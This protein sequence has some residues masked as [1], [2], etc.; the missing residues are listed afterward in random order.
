MYGLVMLTALSSGADPT[1]VPQAVP[2][3]MNCTGCCGAVVSG[4][5]GCYGSYYV[6]RHKHGLFGHHHASCMGCTGYSCDGW[7]CFGS[8]SGCTGSC[9]G[10]TGACFGCDGISTYRSSCFGYSHIGSNNIG[11]GSCFGFGTLQ[12][13]PFQCHGGGF[14]GGAG[15]PVTLPP[16]DISG[17]GWGRGPAYIYGDP[18]AVYGLISR[19]PTAPAP[20]DAKPMEKPKDPSKLGEPT[21]K[22]G[23]G[24]NLKFRLPA[25]AKLYVDGRLTTLEGTERAFTTPPLVPGQKFY[26]D[27]KAEIMVEGKPVFEEKRVVVEAGADIT[28]SFTGLIAAAQGRATPVAGK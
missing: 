11:G 9:W 20:G 25:N 17:Y 24:A 2:M 12:G 7:N 27:V 16:Y 13:T 18:Y 4:C 21:K 10:C 23:M 15:L 6:T 14:G 3:V 22:D 28:A 19:L 8:C 1:P 26:Y 5:S